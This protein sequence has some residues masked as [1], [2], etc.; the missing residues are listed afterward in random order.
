MVPESLVTYLSK[1]KEVSSRSSKQVGLTSRD[2]VVLLTVI[3]TIIDEN[4]SLQ[5]Q[6]DAI[7]A[8]P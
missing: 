2:V 4:K 7:N 5:D 8:L 3:Q 1:L 6:I